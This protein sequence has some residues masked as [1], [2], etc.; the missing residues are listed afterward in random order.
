LTPAEV[1]LL[2]KIDDLK[3]ALT[4]FI[5]ELI[6]CKSITGEEGREA[7]RF[8]K[9]TLKQMGLQT[10]SWTLSKREFKN[11]S[12]LVSMHEFN[13]YRTNVIGWLGHISKR[14]LFCFNGHVDVVPAGAGWR[15]GPFEGII[16]DGKIYGRGA[17]DMKAGLGA[18]LF[19]LYALLESGCYDEHALGKQG[20]IMF[21]SVCGEENGGI[22]TLSAV[23]RGYVAN[24]TIV[25][26][27]TNLQI[28]AAQCG[29]LDFIIKIEGKA[30]HGANRDE[31][32][33]AFEKFI[34]IFK[35]LIELEDRRKK[36][37]HH[38]LYSGIKNVVPLSV[39]KVKA[40]D[41]D[42]TVPEELVAEGRYG[43]WPGESLE[44]AREQF[45]NAVAKASESDRWLS[46]HK[47][48]INWLKPEWEGAEIPPDSRLV[49]D[50]KNAYR[51]VIG[52]KPSVV[53]ETGGTDMRFFTNVAR[54]PA[55]IFGPGNPR[56]A[57]F[58]DEYVEIEQ[59]V[60]ACKIYATIALA[61]I[62]GLT[63]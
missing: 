16:R 43:V 59:V 15:Y 6:Q 34:P 47:P 60:K 11:H 40:G 5:S 19:A 12:D 1:K 53:G 58:K 42:S 45:E 41:W 17:C 44:D 57:H 33:S 14:A 38:P 36:A 29:C 46:K 20:G 52:R 35:A 9:S 51:K 56:L 7:Q 2:K 10:A 63:E 21:Q 25:C 26:E 3:P 13:P 23:L 22:G 18:S 55:V 62:H 39:G 28:A 61:R 32:V 24:E 49:I 8:I 27:P 30:A 48:T 4:A 37:G 31:G 50:L 54:K